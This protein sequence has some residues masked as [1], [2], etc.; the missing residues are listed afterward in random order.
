MDIPPF[1]F[2]NGRKYWLQST[3]RYYQDGRKDASE[4]LLH[5][6]IW[7]ENF[8]EIPD[9]YDVHHKNGDWRDNSIENLKILKRSEHISLHMK[10]RFKDHFY[11]E[12]N[13][14][15][16]S[17]A[18]KAAA[19]WHRSDEAKPIHV[20]AGKKGWINVPFKDRICKVCGISFKS[21]G[22]GDC[23]WCSDKCRQKTRAPRKFMDKTCAY[24]QKPFSTQYKN[25]E[26]CCR[27]CAVAW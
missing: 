20:E 18:Q 16:I 22:H 8:G 14:I 12:Q 25:I 26:C 13:K 11:R 4:R 6:V 17:K 19:E 23:G 15:H 24:C 2:H 27:S 10:E 3:R 7:I 1:V 9:G 5:R 21:R